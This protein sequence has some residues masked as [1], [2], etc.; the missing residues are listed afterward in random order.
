M[1]ARIFDF[2]SPMNPPVGMEGLAAVTTVKL[3][4]RSASRAI[5][6]TTGA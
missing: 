2:D 1:A 6:T 4:Y 5:S 3:R